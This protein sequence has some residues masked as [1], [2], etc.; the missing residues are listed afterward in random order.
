MDINRTNLLSRIIEEIDTSVSIS[1]STVPDIDLYMDQVI[2]FM[3]RYLGS[4]PTSDDDKPLTKTMIN[5]YAKA[6]LLPPPD[7][8]KY[9]KDHILLLTLI[10]YF[11][12]SI[13]LSDTKKIFEPLCEKHFASQSD[14]SLS[15]VQIFDAIYEIRKHN[16]SSLRDEIIE[17][18]NKSEDIFRDI[19]DDKNEDEYLMLFAFACELAFDIYEKKRILELIASYSARRHSSLQNIKKAK[20]EKS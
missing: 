8:K 9:T 20:K 1:S 18:Y 4:K 3:D 12:N 16:M 2:T 15:L 5:N 13:S 11:K 14:T 17:K 10:Y 19:H 6:K 7:K